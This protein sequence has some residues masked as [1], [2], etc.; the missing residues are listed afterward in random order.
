MTPEEA[1]KIAKLQNQKEEIKQLAKQLKLEEN[2]KEA[3]QIFTL[4]I[5]AFNGKDPFLYS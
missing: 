2:W 4:A 1:T 3:I 5:K